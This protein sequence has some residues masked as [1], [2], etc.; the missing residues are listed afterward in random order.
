M[1]SNT[2]TIVLLPTK[3]KSYDNCLSVT[4]IKKQ[5]NMKKSKLFEGDN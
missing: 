5:N 3:L 1:P 2:V 4:N